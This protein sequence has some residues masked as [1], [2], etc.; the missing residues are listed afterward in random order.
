M[1]DEALAQELKDAIP[2][3]MRESHDSADDLAHGRWLSHVAGSSEARR[4]SSRWYWLS[5]PSACSPP[6]IR[7]FRRRHQRCPYPHRLGRAAIH[8]A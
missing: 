4:L 1:S 2:Y 8:R 3:V 6:R 5:L 7:R